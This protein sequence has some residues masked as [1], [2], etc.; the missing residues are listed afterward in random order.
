MA[1]PAMVKR[2][3]ALRALAA[4]LGFAVRR[5]KRDLAPIDVARFLSPIADVLDDVGGV[6]GAYAARDFDMEH[7]RPEVKAE[8][9][10]LAAIAS[11][12][13][14]T[15]TQ[16]VGMHCAAKPKVEHHDLEDDEPPFPIE[17]EFDCD[18][19]AV[20]D[21]PVLSSVL[22]LANEE[23]YPSNLELLTVAFTGWQL[24]QQKTKQER[25]GLTSAYCSRVY[26]RAAATANARWTL[27][28]LEVREMA[29]SV[30]DYEGFL[31]S[32][33]VVEKNNVAS[34]GAPVSVHRP[35]RRVHFP[36]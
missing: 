31:A 2:S 32:K 10:L 6:L 14:P 36:P 35:S 25:L 1:L 34:A 13:S 17:D 30:K 15:P 9:S 20:P 4:R 19:L 26:Q 3:E 28:L 16:A 7:A 27:L 33:D 24:E 8:T 29:R 11:R 23:P 5:A 18:F 12:P 21:F 22:S